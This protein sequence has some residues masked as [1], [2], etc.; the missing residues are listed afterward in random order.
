VWDFL[1]DEARPFIA[2]AV[3]VWGIEVLAT[4][5]ADGPA[6]SDREAAGRELLRLIFGTQHESGQLPAP[7][8]DPIADPASEAA[9]AG[10]SRQMDRILEADPR[11]SAAAA[12]MITGFYR[13]QADAG[14]IQA[15]VDVGGFLCWDAPQAACAAYQQAVD[16]GHQ[17]A[18]LHLA[19]VLRVVIED[20]DAALGVYR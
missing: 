4:E 10:L 15:L 9:V 5:G 2:A 7:L 16:A 19:K 8:A 6:A 17:H 3:R 13:R 20:D 12:D 14:D 1:A 18:L 11:L